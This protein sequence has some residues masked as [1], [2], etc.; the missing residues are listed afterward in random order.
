[1]VESDDGAVAFPQRAMADL[2]LVTGKPHDSSR[3][4]DG[5]GKGTLVGASACVGRI[6]CND[7]LPPN[8]GRH[9]K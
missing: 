9:K 3:W 8:Y 1:M 6:E 5:I 4:V 2:I 7:A